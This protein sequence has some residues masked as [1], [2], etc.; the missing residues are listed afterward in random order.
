MQEVLVTVIVGTGF[1]GMTAKALIAQ[2]RAG[3]AVQLQREPHNPHDTRAV[4]CHYRGA[5]V[6]YIPRQANPRIAEALDACLPVT[7]AVREPAVVIEDRNG[8]VI[9]IEPK[10]TVAWPVLP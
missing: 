7:C 3:D 4:A 5:H 10:L 8:F 2:M 6:G 9:R 1:K